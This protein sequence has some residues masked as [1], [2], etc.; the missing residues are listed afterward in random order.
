MKGSSQK[1]PNANKAPLT[2]GTQARIQ[3]FVPSVP[4][5]KG[6]KPFQES[7]RDKQLVDPGLSFSLTFYWKLTRAGT[8]R[9]A[10]ATS[11]ESPSGTLANDWAP[12]HQN[13]TVGANSTIGI[14][15]LIS[16]RSSSSIALSS[17]LITTISSIP[18]TLTGA[19]T[20]SDLESYYL[21]SL[22]L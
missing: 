13:Q 2:D 16:A 10:T 19:F 17:I 9:A 12:R 8:S 22:S 4:V 20:S 21:S 15:F 7:S 6:R 11:Q 18:E 3:T 14:Y 1:K 5:T